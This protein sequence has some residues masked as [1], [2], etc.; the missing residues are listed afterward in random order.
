MA[1]KK[2]KR[3]VQYKPRSIDDAAY[4]VEDGK[5]TESQFYNWLLG[6]KEDCLTCE[7]CVYDWEIGFFICDSGESWNKGGICPT[8]PCEQYF[9]R[10][11]RE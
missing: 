4:L 6:P 1:K 3:Y 7:F 8:H 9:R 5:W 2:F 10:S 11:L